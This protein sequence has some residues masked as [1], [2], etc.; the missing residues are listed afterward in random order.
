[1]RLVCTGWFYWTDASV[2]MATA[3]TP[4]LEFVPPMI[5]I[6][7]QTDE[8]EVWQPIGP[9]VGFP[10]GKTK[11]MVIDLTDILNRK[12]P[13]LRI[14][15]TLTLYWDSLRLALGDRAGAQKV[16]RLEP[17]QSDLWFRGFSAPIETR[18]SDQPERFD[19]ETL[20]E[21]ARWNQHPGLYTRYGDTLPLLK[22]IDDQ[23]IIMGSGD[24]L[25]LRFDASK[26]PA[27]QP[28]FVRDYLIFLD[29]WAKDRDPNSVQALE[30]EPLPF[31]GMGSYPYPEELSFPDDAEHLEWRKEWNNR[32]AKRL[33][34]PLA[35]DATSEWFAARD[36]PALTARRR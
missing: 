16:T 8:G 36:L 17:V 33:L 6:P 1:L 14:Q 19:F 29:G 26:A 11:T 34:L 10:A 2:N 27:L 5:L 35:S 23:F 25:T 15:S 13:R 22:T 9:P 20:T 30:V 7:V 12:D 24:A 21:T 31:H 28:G 18:L 4:D 3:R 32:P